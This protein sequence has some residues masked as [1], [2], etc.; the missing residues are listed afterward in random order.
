MRHSSSLHILLPLVMVG[1]MTLNGCDSREDQ[2][3]GQQFD[4]SVQKADQAVEKAQSDT[5]SAM[6]D[7]ERMIAEAATSAGNKIDDTAN[8]AEMQA[9]DAAITARVNAS[10]IADDQLKASKIDVDTLSGEV[11]LRGEAPNAQAKDRAADLAMSVE[12]VKDVD[13]ELTVSSNK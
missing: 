12:G 13:N 6:S 10:L 3:V 8:K 1:T 11:T 4:E 9:R 7:A 5:S 2:T